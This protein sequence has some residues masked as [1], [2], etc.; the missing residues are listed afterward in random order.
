MLLQHLLQILPSMRLRIFRNLFPVFPQQL[1]LLLY[2]HLQDRD[3]SSSRSSKSHRDYV[4]SRSVGFAQSQSPSYPYRLVFA[5]DIGE[6]VHFD[7]I[8]ALSAT[9][10][11]AFTFD[12]EGKLSRFIATGFGFGGWGEDFADGVEYACVG[13]GIRSRVK[14]I[15][16]QPNQ[17]MP[18][19]S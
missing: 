13:D 14:P 12:V 15:S 6:K 11:T 5:V 16:I 7:D 10:F 4:R 1:I 9:G 19:W 3:R 18:T 2:Y 17:K 8:Y